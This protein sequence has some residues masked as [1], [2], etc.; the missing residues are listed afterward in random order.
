MQ[1]RHPGLSKPSQAS[2]RGWTRTLEKVEGRQLLARACSWAEQSLGQPEDLENLGR[3]QLLTSPLGTGVGVQGL[4]PVWPPGTT[5]THSALGVPEPEDL[6]LRNTYLVKDATPDSHVV[7]QA[8]LINVVV[9]EAPEW[10][11]SLSVLSQLLRLS[12]EAKQD[13]ALCYL[14]P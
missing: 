2:S 11:R 13:P 7:E 8:R 5:G 10:I 4:L 12:L 3:P 9:L 6:Y 1:N 14:I